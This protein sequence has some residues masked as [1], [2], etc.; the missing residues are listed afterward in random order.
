MVAAPGVGFAGGD[1]PALRHRPCVTIRFR[2]FATIGAGNAGGTP[3][4]FSPMRPLATLRAALPIAS[5]RDRAPLLGHSER[6]PT[7][8]ALAALAMLAAGCG[9]DDTT[10]DSGDTMASL[11]GGG[12]TEESCAALGWEWC[13]ESCVDVQLDHDHCGACG[14][15][16]SPDAPCRS[17]ECGGPCPSGAP[18]ACGRE[19]CPGRCDA[20]GLACGAPS[21]EC[22]DSP[23]ADGERCAD[24]G[25][26]FEGARC[27]YLRCEGEGF[28]MA[29]C[30]GEAETWSVTATACAD[31]ECGGMTCDG[32]QICVERVGGALLT[33]CA[34]SPCG[35]G[36]LYAHC[37][38]ELCP[39]GAGCSVLGR[40]VSCNTCTD[41]PCP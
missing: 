1:Q 34:E 4:E 13:D 3:A 28:V 5:E 26:S 38:C 30:D 15:S 41:S 22:P 17:G 29:R 27:D 39:D 40:A 9:D 2:F 7:R 11:D 21:L 16:C 37:M 36:P 19:C 10:P 33:E 24:I 32:A 14:T 25:Y 35:E 6:M 12:L 23:P 18:T 8:L 31:V 20:T